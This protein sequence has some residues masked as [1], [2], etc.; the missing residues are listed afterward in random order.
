MSFS[1][2]KIVVYIGYPVEVISKP[3]S[4][5]DSLLRSESQDPANSPFRFFLSGGALTPPLLEVLKSRGEERVSAQRMAMKLAQG[6]TSRLLD[7]ILSPDIVKLAALA[8]EN[9]LSTE[10]RLLLDL[11]VLSRSDVYVVDCDLMGRARCGMEAVYAHH[12]TKTVGVA[13]SPVMDPWFQYH[14]DVLVKS[15]MCMPFL[16]S[17]RHAILASRVS[18]GASGAT[19]DA[20]ETS[21]TPEQ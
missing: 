13:D 8:N 5:V 1:D 9:P 11:W 21:D 10:Y 7:A 19:Q 6:Y 3:P 18:S 17:L 20:K 2:D 12:V 16:T 4:W 15:Q 14:L